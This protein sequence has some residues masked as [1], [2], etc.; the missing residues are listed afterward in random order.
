MISEGLIIFKEIFTEIM[1]ENVCDDPVPCP[2][3][4]RVKGSEG[5]CNENLAN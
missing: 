5:G 2:Q 4:T 3:P 1:I